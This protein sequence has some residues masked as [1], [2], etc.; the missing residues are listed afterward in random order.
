[1]P[2]SLSLRRRG[3]GLLRVR[4]GLRGPAAA[5]VSGAGQPAGHRTGTGRP[6]RGHAGPRPG[7]RPGRRHRRLADDAPL[8]ADPRPGGQRR[9]RRRRSRARS[10]SSPRAGFSTT[11]DCSGNATARFSPCSAPPPGV[12]RVRGRGRHV[13]FDVSQLMI[14]KQVT[15]HGSWVT[16]VPAWP[17]CS[18]SSTGGRPIPSRSSPTPSASTR[19]Q[20]PTSW[21]TAAPPARCASSGT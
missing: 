9:P 5:R 16:S 6:R 18:T 8:A 21:P 15:L 7:G 20:R 12:V 14:H 13:G 10:K 3:T 2:D 4:D 1:M 11:V 17:T 19:P